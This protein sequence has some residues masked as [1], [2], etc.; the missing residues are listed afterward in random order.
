MSSL[1]VKI[2]GYFKSV[3]FAWLR[4]RFYAFSKS[5]GLKYTVLLSSEY[6]K[7]EKQ[8]ISQNLKNGFLNLHDKANLH[9]LILSF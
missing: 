3:P 1:K 7:V 8:I 2:L 9:K 5:S 6:S 4:S